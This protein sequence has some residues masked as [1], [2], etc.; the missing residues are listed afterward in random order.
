MLALAVGQALYRI[1]DLPENAQGPVDDLCD[2]ADRFFERR[3]QFGQVG[4]C[5]DESAV[6]RFVAVS[7]FSRICGR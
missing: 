2:K 5:A 7:C 6:A 4:L 1:L 3:S